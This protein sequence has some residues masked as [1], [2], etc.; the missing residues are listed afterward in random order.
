M[1]SVHEDKATFGIAS[2]FITKDN[3]QMVDFLLH[4]NYYVHYKTAKP[5]ST[6]P[7]WN[8]VKP[9][10]WS[11]WLALIACFIVVTAIFIVFTKFFHDESSDLVA[12]GM[13]IFQ[14]HFL[15]CKKS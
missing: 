11:S 7:T 5:K 3:W 15:Q 9:F 10:T 2:V 6:A 13:M 1:G 12:T 8:I 4:Y 14:I